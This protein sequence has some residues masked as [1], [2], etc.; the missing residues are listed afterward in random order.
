MN[1]NEKILAECDKISKKAEIN[2]EILSRRYIHYNNLDNIFTFLIITLSAL[3]ATIAMI[4]TEIICLFIKIDTAIA[5]R[6]IIVIL[7][8]FIL[9]FTLLD[10]I[11][12]FR[13]RKITSEKGIDLLTNFL[14]DIHHFRKTKCTDCEEEKAQ[15]EMKKYI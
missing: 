8:L 6:Q 4:D 10:K 7:G 14:R 3:I 2:R 15:N 11:W 5:L 13:E 1:E 12:D 9:I